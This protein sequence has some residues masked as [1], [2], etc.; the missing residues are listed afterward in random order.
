LGVHLDGHPGFVVMAPSASQLLHADLGRPAHEDCAPC[1]VAACWNCGSPYDRGVELD[2][3]LKASLT[4]Q[5]T[6]RAPHSTLVCEACVYVRARFSPVPGRLPKEGRENGGRFS[7]YSHLLDTAESVPYANASKG[8]K[9]VI[10]AFLRR[11]HAG[12]WFAAIADSG[13]KHVLPYAPVNPPGSRGRVRFD[14][15]TISLP[16]AAGWALVDDMV[17]LL[18]AGATKEELASGAYGARAWQLCG[19][20]LASFEHAWGR[21]RGDA[22]FAL[23]VWLAQRNEE[24]VAARMAAEKTAKEAATRGKTQRTAAREVANADNGDAPRD[25]PRV[26]RER[27]QRHHAL[28]ASAEHAPVGIEALRDARR[29]VDRD[30]PPPAT[31]DAW[32]LSLPGLA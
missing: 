21:L 5:N 15:R 23:A 2:R 10:L 24:A 18:T 20:H 12:H 7:N 32:Q 28:G 17:A 6:A 19:E 9:P 27:G 25:A 22:W 4:D 30:E 1:D 3:L 29:G 16:D 11:H 13:Q 31:A 14:D 8:E 26:S